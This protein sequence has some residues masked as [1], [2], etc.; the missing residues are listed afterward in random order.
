MVSNSTLR[1]QVGVL[2]PWRRVPRQSLKHR[3]AG[4]EVAWLLPGLNPIKFIPE[5]NA[6]F[7]V[8]LC[9]N[10]IPSMSNLSFVS[11]C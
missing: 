10:I 4:T 1:L 7:C 2:F 9:F 5:L 11:R 8:P 3:W 6:T